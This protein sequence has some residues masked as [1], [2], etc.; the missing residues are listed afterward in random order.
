M[1][2]EAQMFAQL[3]RGLDR[4]YMKVN[5]LD[6]YEDRPTGKK[7]CAT[8]FWV[9][10]KL[11]VD[12]FERHLLGKQGIGVGPVTDNDTSFFGVIDIDE[13]NW[14][15]NRVINLCHRIEKLQL[16][17]VPA[18]SKSKGV[19][20]YL[21]CEESPGEMVQSYLRTCAKMLS[22]TNV[23]IFP[24]SFKLVKSET[25]KGKGS[26]VALPYFNGNNT[27]CSAFWKNESLNVGEFI[28]FALSKLISTAQLKTIPGINL[29]NAETF[30]D[31]PPCLQALSINGFS[32]GT[33][34]NG[35]FNIGVYLRLKYGDEGPDLHIDDYN[36]KCMVPP[37]PSKDVQSALRS[38][39]KKTYFYTCKKEPICNACNKELC[40]T[41]K[42]GIGSG[43]GA[44]NIKIGHIVKYDC[45]PP[46]WIVEVNNKRIEF[47]TEE[48]F[49]SIRAFI[50]K[51]IEQLHIIPN[52][53]NAKLKPL[54]NQALEKA[55][56]VE[57]PADA[58]LT[59]QCIAYLHQYLQSKPPAKVKDELAYNYPWY[60][61]G[62]VYFRGP[63]FI[64]YLDM[65]KFRQLDA[66]KVSAILRE[67]NKSS[68]G[69][70]PE[71]KIFKINKRLIRTR[72]IKYDKPEFPVEM[73]EE[74]F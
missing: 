71:E 43:S 21:F 65:Q 51:C 70:L 3:F 24:N 8:N 48:L 45:E 42:Y 20:L 74:E 22:F 19:R 68:G 5:L 67:F 7:R 59:G 13:Y 16:P 50:K 44:A 26:S 31:G 52:V 34:G 73:D 12:T 10:K 47:E 29:E 63:D 4:A 17:L 9:E 53:T 28:K 11:T 55:E 23:E 57:A 49:L 72:C 32:E 1:K 62:Y 2:K 39:K 27:E 38:V 35:L 61:D 40:H 33:R 30:A 14:S 56:T 46:I 69:E 64:Q 18:W 58:S 60:E 6:K 37:L 54:L 36:M 15:E 41:R 66:R 25:D